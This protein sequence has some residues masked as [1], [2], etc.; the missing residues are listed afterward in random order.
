M[1]TGGWGAK[2]APDRNGISSSIESYLIGLMNCLETN[3]AASLPRSMA[4]AIES[5]PNL[6]MTESVS[7]YIT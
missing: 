4:S 1:R 2:S 5:T 7:P 6:T 3:S